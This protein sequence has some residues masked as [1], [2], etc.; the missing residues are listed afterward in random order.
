MTIGPEPITRIDRIAVRFGISATPRQGT[1]AVHQS[2]KLA[3]E[4]TRVMGT[5]TS[6]GVILHRERSDLFR[7]D[8]LDDAIVEVAVRN[9]RITERGLAHGVSMVLRGDLDHT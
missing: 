6:L 7:G 3:E 2:G 9:G 8:S 4:I 5:R 1:G